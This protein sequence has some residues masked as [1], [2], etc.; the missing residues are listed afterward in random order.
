MVCGKSPA[1]TFPE[2][3]GAYAPRSWLLHDRSSVENRLL[4]CTNAHPVKSGGRQ[5]AVVRDTNAVP[6][7]IEHHSATYERT[8]K[9]GG[10]EP[11]VVCTRW[12]VAHS[13][14]QV[15]CKHVSRTT[16]GLRPPL[17]VA[18]TR[19]VADARLCFATAFRLPRG[20]YAPRSCVAV[21]TSAEE[22]RFLRCTI[23]RSQ[24]RRA[25]AR[26]GSLNVIIA[27]RA[28]QIT[29]RL[30]SQA[31]AGLRQPLLVVRCWSLRK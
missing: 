15:T 8:T 7:K 24:E 19:V 27:D 22:K 5:P 9:S 10:R 1:S 13:V 31:T 30:V 26:R 4:R 21:R 17:L 20:A 28:S 3:R 29:C 14:R 6:R 18:P 12:R 16:G 11:A 23:A 25:S 2:P